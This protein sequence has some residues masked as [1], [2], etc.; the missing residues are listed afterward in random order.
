MR[1]IFQTPQLLDTTEIAL[2]PSILKKKKGKK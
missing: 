2:S 1:G